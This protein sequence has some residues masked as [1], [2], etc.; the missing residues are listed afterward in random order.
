M[1]RFWPTTRGR[2]HLADRDRLQLC[3]SGVYLRYHASLAAAIFVGPA[4]P[5]L[6]RLFRHQAS[7]SMG[8]LPRLL[9]GAAL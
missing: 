1:A 4:E 6:Q 2:R 5:Q 7:G 3:L 9:R 8:E